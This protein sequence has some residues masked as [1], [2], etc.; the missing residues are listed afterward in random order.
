MAK[1]Q[2]FTL[3]N[4]TNSPRDGDELGRDE[5]LEAMLV[6]HGGRDFVISLDEDVSLTTKMEEAKI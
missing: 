6:Q 5:Q 2:H 3:L 4:K 1:D